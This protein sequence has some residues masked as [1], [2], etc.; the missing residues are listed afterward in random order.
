MKKNISIFLTLKLTL[1]VL[2]CS[3][4]SET[5]QEKN[6]K[7]QEPV[8]LS[9]KNKLTL[10]S[11]HYVL[12]GVQNNMYAETF[13]KRWKPY[14]YSIRFSGSQKFS[15]TLSNVASI[16]EPETSKKIDIQLINNDDFK[17]IDSSTIDIVVGKRAIGTHKISASIIGDSYTQGGFFKDALLNNGHVPNLSLI[18]LRKNSENQYDEGRGGWTLNNYFSICKTDIN[19]N[20][21][22][23]PNNKQYWGSIQ[24][25]KNAHAVFNKTAG[26][27]FEPRYSAG[28]YDDYLHLFDQNSGFKQNPSI[29]DV[30][31]NSENSSFIEWNGT[32]WINKNEKDYTWEVNYPKYISMWKLNSPDFLFVMLGVN[33]FRNEND[34]ENIDFTLWNRQMEILKKSYISS[35]SNGKFAIV[36]PCSVFGKTDNTSNSFTLKAN[37][38]LWSCRK[39]IIDTFDSREKEQIYV[40]DGGITV[41]S[42][43]GYKHSKSSVFTKPFDTYKGD[44]SINVHTGVPHPY[45]SYPEIGKPLAAFI[46]SMR[47]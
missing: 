8:T 39:N 21:F 47:K 14:D 30:M 44:Q 28:R 22:F 18:G 36:I 4:T 33:D 40:V 43:Y 31:Y 1:L 24:F 13:T 34:P 27:S 11:K 2:L 5:K 45:L 16:T 3:C 17:V 37:A 7:I 23:Q 26:R 10:P 19:Y 29:G 20:P 41:D 38:C 15:R 9:F 46:Q 25:W 35:N 12:S 42:E 32:S 6:D